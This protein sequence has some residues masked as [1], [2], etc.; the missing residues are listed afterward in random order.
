MGATPEAGAVHLAMPDGRMIELAEGRNLI[1]REPQC[2]VVLEVQGVSREHACIDV[3]LAAGGGVWV[4]DLGS[5]NGT[6][7]GPAGSEPGGAQKLAER[8]QLLS[9]DHIWIGGQKLTVLF[10]GRAAGGPAA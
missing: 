1:G 7:S 9:G 6:Y 8:R 2:K 5:T 10:A 4:E 3:Q